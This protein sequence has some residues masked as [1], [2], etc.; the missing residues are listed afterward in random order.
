VKNSISKLFTG[1]MK[2]DY[3]T[4]MVYGWYVNTLNQGQNY[5]Y[6]TVSMVNYVNISSLGFQ[7]Q[8][9]YKGTLS[10]DRTFLSGEYFYYISI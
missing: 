3:D 9:H 4:R 5:S 10:C 6:N 1:I 7:H 8:Q 2:V